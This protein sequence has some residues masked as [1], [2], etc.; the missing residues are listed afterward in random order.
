[1]WEWRHRLTYFVLNTFFSRNYV[2]VAERYRSS[3]A[4]ANTTVKTWASSRW[5][6]MYTGGGGETW[7]GFN[8]TNNR[9]KQYFIYGSS[10]YVTTPPPLFWW[11]LTHFP[12]IYQTS[13]CAYF[14]IISLHI[15]NKSWKLS[16][17][18]KKWLH[19]MQMSLRTRLLYPPPKK[20][21]QL[22]FI[23]IPWSYIFPQKYQTPICFYFN[24]SNKSG[25]YTG[26]HCTLQ[27]VLYMSSSENT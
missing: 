23:L 7:A 4:S 13:I 12:T 26:L 24:I 5:W 22:Y 27:L 21:P 19:V 15:Q 25:K 2:I 9:K 6:D 16:I 14:K 20:K 10:L 8:C 18:K 17:W 3:D 1:M 11:Y